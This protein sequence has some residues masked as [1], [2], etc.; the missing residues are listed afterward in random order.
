MVS[1]GAN[2]AILGHFA[3]FNN[4]ATGNVAVGYQASY[5]L[6]TAQNV[7][8]GAGSQT[9][10][11]LT[12]SWTGCTSVGVNTLTAN[13]TGADDNTAAGE[14]ALQSNTI[15]VEN[16]AFGFS[17][18]SS[19]TTGSNNSILGY[20][21]GTS[22]TAGSNNIYIDG[23]SLAPA[24]ESDTIRIGNTQTRCFVQGIRGITTGVA[25]AIPVVIDSAGQVGTISSSKRFKHN[26]QEMEKESSSVLA[27]RPVTFAY[28]QDAANAR[29]YGLVAEE[30]NEIMP[31]LV[32]KDKDGLPLTVRY[33][34][35]S[36]LLLN[37]M[38]KQKKTLGA[39]AI[40]LNDLRHVVQ[41]HF[42]N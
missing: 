20:S 2:C 28:N 30:V 6:Q 26:I 24:D 25:D 40:S 3:G 17:A 12:N 32:I 33:E 18:G 14:G 16:T 8:V 31:N 36:V 38:K 27:L 19:I 21:V 1:G 37:E 22:T 5:S 11:G 34:A 10:S 42:V 35:L 29:Q 4:A 41:K 9:G 7:S 15:G 39:M 13:V 23:N